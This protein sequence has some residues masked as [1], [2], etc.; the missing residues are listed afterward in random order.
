MTMRS[1]TVVICAYTEDRWERLCEA[2]ASA[3]DGDVASRVLIVIDHNPE[4]YARARH[5]WPAHQVVQNT[6]RQ[7]LSGA[8]NTALDL[9]EDEIVAFLDDDAA[10]ADGWLE[11]LVEPFAEPSVVATGGRAE[12]VWPGVRPA[13]L[14][15]ELWWI[16]GCS[17]RGQPEG[18]DVRNVMGCNMA[19]R[20]RELRAV[21]GFDESLGRVGT[22]PVGAEETDACIRLTR[23][24]P[25]ARIAFTPDA[26]V[27]HT[28]TL[29]RTRMRYLV[30][31]SF[32]EGVSKAALG[33][34]LGPASALSTESAYVR[35]VLPRAVGRELLRPHR[36][37]LVGAFAITTSTAAAAVGYLY[38]RATPA[39][40]IRPA[41]AVTP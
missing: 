2:V 40:R 11:A 9:V 14:P 36:G 26:V 18:R 37:G 15:S 1:I 21:G 3:G 28:V 16:V 31:R 29:P 30:A 23:L 35:R 12:P 41:L 5:T 24:R 8:R 6:H 4:L 25:G 17:F 13:S 34:R 39:P 7:G 22:V 27:H 20:A 33:R 10:G 32:G 19:F 38:G